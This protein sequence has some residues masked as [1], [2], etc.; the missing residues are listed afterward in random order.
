MEEEEYEAYKDGDLL[1]M[2]TNEVAKFKVLT[3]K[4]ETLLMGEIKEGKAHVNRLVE[5]NL[6][7]ALYVVFRYRRPGDP[8]M[9][10]VSGAFMGLIKSAKYFNPEFGYRFI[11]YAFPAIRREVLSTRFRD[12]LEFGKSLDD[13][14]Y[15]N[16]DCMK[17]RLVSEE[18]SPEEEAET[19][20]LTRYFTVLTP[21]ERRVIELRF[22]ED[23]TLEEVGLI[24]GICVESVRQKEARALMKLR[25]A[26]RGTDIKWQ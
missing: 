21:K 18:S 5:A 13:P 24:F 9:S 26:M 10:M 2:L 22:W 23:K 11:S 7:F 16:G 14:I 6:R 12:N 3:R 4:E 15:E 1:K 25:L 8:L 17:D 19:K 20:D